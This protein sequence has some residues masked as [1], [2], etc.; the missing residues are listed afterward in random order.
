MFGSH[1]E[2]MDWDD[3]RVVLT[4]A[5]SGIGRAL[6]L[7]LA[8]RGA[9]LALVA[10]RAQMLA[11]LAATI[12]ENGGRPPLVVPCD[13][14]D[15]AQVSALQAEVAARWGGTDVLINNA[16]RG[17]YHALADADVRECAAVVQTNLLGVIYCTRAFLPGM[18]ARGRG[19]LV[20]ISSVVGEF[21]VPKHAVY[22]AT[23]FA[24]NGL[25]ESLEYE[26]A[27][28]GIGVHL[29]GPGLVHTEFAE[30]A[31]TKHLPV[32]K[33]FAK[34]AEEVAEAIADAVAAG[35]RKSVPDAAAQLLIK[36]RQHV[37]RLTRFAFKRVCRR[38]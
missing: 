23:K 7:V 4:G 1:Y 21:P 13:V 35:Q 6:A 37:P 29:V 14:G 33:K 27:P 19:R 31:G 30:R 38:L 24:V 25:A 8:A 18:L 11:E 5:S 36:L 3:Q 28:Q 26:L 17:Y 34:S 15:W 12:E 16:G 9:R 32:Q 10:R 2:K 22:S 20:F